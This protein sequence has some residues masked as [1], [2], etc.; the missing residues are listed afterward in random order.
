MDQAMQQAKSDAEII[1]KRVSETIGLQMGG[2]IGQSQTPMRA[3]LKERVAMRAAE[4]RSRAHK[5]DRLKEL[6]HLL[7]KNPDVTRILELM[8]EM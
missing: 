4:A 1:N 7:D 3:P 8:D 6:Q 5:A 2:L